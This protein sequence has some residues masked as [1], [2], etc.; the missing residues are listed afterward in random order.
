LAAAAAVVLHKPLG[1][2]RVLLVVVL[3]VLTATGEMGQ[4]TQVVVAVA[5][6]LQAYQAPARA[7]QVVLAMFEFLGGRQSNGTFRKN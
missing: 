5:V 4:L 6:L 3:A 2:A 1:R 7:A